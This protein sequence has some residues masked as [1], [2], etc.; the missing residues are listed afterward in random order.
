[1]ISHESPQFPGWV[2]PRRGERVL[3][4]NPSCGGELCRLR[5]WSDGAAE[6]GQPR[7]PDSDPVCLPEKIIPY[8]RETRFPVC[9]ALFKVNTKHLPDT[10]EVLSQYFISLLVSVDK[11]VSCC[12]TVGVRVSSIA[13]RE[14]CQSCHFPRSVSFSRTSAGSTC[15]K[16]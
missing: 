6:E 3:E 14:P 16:Q 11:S 9:A 4:P 12:E 5:A 2:S 13:L 1:M 10:P 7:V 15:R 8:P